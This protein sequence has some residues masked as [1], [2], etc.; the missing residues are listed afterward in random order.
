MPGPA[1]L[2]YWFHSLLLN[3]MAS[4]HQGSLA[5]NRSAFNFTQEGPTVGQWTESHHVEW[6]SGILSCSLRWIEHTAC[7]PRA[8]KNSFHFS[9]D[10]SP[11]EQQNGVCIKEYAHLWLVHRHACTPMPMFV[12]GQK[13]TGK[14]K[15]QNPKNSIFHFPSS[16]GTLSLGE[17]VYRN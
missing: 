13:T 16:Q 6:W 2:W 15:E 17:V 4:P 1:S 14:K 3:E 10:H 5:P 11:K 7:R 9:N 8:S 12:W